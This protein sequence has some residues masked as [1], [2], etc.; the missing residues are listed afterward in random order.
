[1]TPIER[2]ERNDVY[3]EHDAYKHKPVAYNNHDGLDQL[4]TPCGHEA[5][6]AGAHPSIPTYS[7]T[8][9]LRHMRF[10]GQRSIFGAQGIVIL[11][12]S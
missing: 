5:C 8:H 12:W 10:A 3:E 7:M 4:P 11:Q 1:M 2:H 6:T 9:R